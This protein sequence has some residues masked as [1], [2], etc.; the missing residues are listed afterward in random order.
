MIKY[1]YIT[2]LFVLMLGSNN[3]AVAYDRLPGGDFIAGDLITVTTLF[4]DHVIRMTDTLAHF[5]DFCNGGGSSYVYLSLLNTQE[6]ALINF[7]NGNVGGFKPVI[8]WI[9][10]EFFYNLGGNIPATSNWTFSN[11][12]DGNYAV[13]IQCRATYPSSTNNQY[14][15]DLYPSNGWI[16]ED[17]NISGYSSIIREAET[18]T[19]VSHILTITTTSLPATTVGV[20]YSQILKKSDGIAPFDWSIV[21]GNLPTG[22]FLNNSTG[23]VF[24]VAMAAGSATF[25]VEVTDANNQADIKALTVVVHDKPSI[26]TISLPDGIALKSYSQDL[27][28]ITGTPPYFWSVE[29]GIFPPGLLLN[30]GGSISGSPNT[31]GSYTFALQVQDVYGVTAARQFT[32]NIGPP[33]TGGL[34]AI[35]TTPED[36]PINFVPSLPDFSNFCHGGGY[37]D[38]YLALLNTNGGGLGNFLDNQIGGAQPVTHWVSNEFFRGQGGGIPTTVSWTFSGVPN[39]NYVVAVQCQSARPLTTNNPHSFDLWPS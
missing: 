13:A 22:L 15:L 3:Q 35:T 12:P 8:H 19:V 28:V 2:V 10:N 32:V 25:T 38:F 20:N 6:G 17:G 9:S 29:S 4:S 26:T 23:E 1:L 18:F 21:S 14:G 36:T 33:L 5:S 16:L 27:Q 39:D 7:F 37:E 30:P 24:G 31:E 34:I 11:V